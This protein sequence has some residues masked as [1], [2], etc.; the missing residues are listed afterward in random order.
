MSQLKAR[1]NLIPGHVIGVFQGDITEE[2]VDAIVNAA[3][4]SLAHGGGL[5]AAIVHRGGPVI[6]QESDEWVLK[7][8][9]VPPGGVAL[10][11]A[12]QLPCRAVI[13]AVGPIWEGGGEG[14]DEKLRSAVWESLKLARQCEF[15][16]IALPPIS[17]GIFGFPKDRCAR[18]LLSAARQFAEENP[19][20]PPRDIR[21]VIIDRATLVQFE[22]EFHRTFGDVT[23]ESS[24]G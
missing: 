5:A 6:Q 11:G 4:S 22:E 20:S 17:S 1:C 3:N 21:F 13:H 2:S 15:R 19:E 8:G 12:G 24:A 23:G 7:H 10:T 18:I 9:L 14:E 16:S